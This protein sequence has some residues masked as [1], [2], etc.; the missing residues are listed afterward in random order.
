MAE[1]AEL[2][3]NLMGRFSGESFKFLPNLLLGKMTYT[4]A[5]YKKVLVGSPTQLKIP[6]DLVE[7]GEVQI[8]S[9]CTDPV[10]LCQTYEPFLRRMIRLINHYSK[11]VRDDLDLLSKLLTLYRHLVEAGKYLDYWSR[12]SLRQENVRNLEEF[13][14]GFFQ[15]VN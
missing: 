14:E 13:R 1:V 6:E 15:L 2:L 11:Q 5:Y 4:L 10:L 7:D 12:T 3:D 8:M 9:R